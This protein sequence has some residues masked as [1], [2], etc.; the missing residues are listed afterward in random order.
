MLPVRFASPLPE[1]TNARRQ[2]QYSS[3]SSYLHTCCMDRG[4]GSGRQRRSGVW[5][6]AARRTRAARRRVPACSRLVGALHGM[7]MGARQAGSAS[8]AGRRRA[9]GVGGQFRRG[10]VGSAKGEGAGHKG[11]GP[12]GGARAPRAEGSLQAVRQRRRAR[13]AARWPS[14]AQ[15]SARAHARVG[16]QGGRALAMWGAG[17]FGG[18]AGERLAGK[19]PGGL[20]N[21][22]QRRHAPRARRLTAR[23]C[24]TT[25]SARTGG[26]PSATARCRC[27]RSRGRAPPACAPR[28][29]AAG[30]AP[31]PR[32]ASL[33]S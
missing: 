23:A 15:R 22:S 14:L 2:P 1:R 24:C 7:G 3:S 33:S 21:G 31:R 8:R 6:G 5:W 12:A 26:T 16:I 25:G 11:A 9:E 30:A 29:A 27:A 13:G 32:A 17:G 19:K 10:S 4:A 18:R 28:T 20:Q